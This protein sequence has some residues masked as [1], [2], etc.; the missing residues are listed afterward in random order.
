MAKEISIDLKK[1]GSKKLEILTNLDVTIMRKAISKALNK[2]GK[3]LKQ[4][5]AN[6][7]KPAFKMDQGQAFIDKNIKKKNSKSTQRIWDQ[8]VDV[9]F[10]RKTTSLIKYNASESSSGIIHTAPKEYVKPEVARSSFFGK[11]RNNNQVLVRT[12]KVKDVTS[13]RVYKTNAQ[14]LR[15]S[16]ELP[17]TKLTVTSTNKEATKNYPRIESYANNSMEKN[18]LIA[19]EKTANKALLK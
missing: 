2:T 6:L 3:E 8:S 5:S 16:S 17:V 11:I 1:L 12:T 19:L 4:Y 13:R 18:I 10:T 7:M 15:I 14:G 9:N